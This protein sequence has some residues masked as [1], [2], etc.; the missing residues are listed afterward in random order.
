MTSRLARLGLL[1]IGLPLAMSACAWSDPMER[2]GLWT[3]RGANNGNLAAQ[4]V[5]PYDLVQGKNAPM[6]D[7]VLAA[8]AVDRL[9]T[10]KV[11]T[12]TTVTN[13]TNVSGTTPTPGGSPESNP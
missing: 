5:D 9:Y 8:G 11:K 12:P 7:G 3:P 6:S 2:E 10:G 1:A 4:I 13:A